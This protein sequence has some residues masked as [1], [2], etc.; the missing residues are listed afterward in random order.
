MRLPEVAR[1]EMDGMPVFHIDGPRPFT[2]HLVFRVGVYDEALRD[3]GI[4]HLVEHLALHPLR[5]S[6][7]AFNGSVSSHMTTFTAQGHPDEVGQFLRSVCSSIHDLGFDRLPVEVDVLTREEALR[8]FSQFD[9]IMWAYF[10][11]RGPGVAGSTEFGLTWLPPSRIAEWAGRFFTRDNA[12]ILIIGDPPDSF[13]L[14]L[15][16]GEPMHY[17][18]PKR[19]RRS[20]ESPTLYTTQELGLTWGTLIRHPKGAA[21]PSFFVGLDTVTQRLQD[22]LRHDLGRT[23]SIPHGWHRIDAELMAAS[24]GFDCDPSQAR[25]AALEHLDVVHEFISTGPTQE[26]LDR[27]LRIQRKG[28]EDHPQAAAQYHLFDEAESHLSGW[29]P[30]TSA[31]EYRRQMELLTA[32]EVARRFEE[33]YRQ[34][35]TVADLPPEK[36]SSLQSLIDFSATPLPGV[37]FQSPLRHQKHQAGR[38]RIGPD[39]FS[40]FY[41]EGWLNTQND[42]IG[43]VIADEVGVHLFGDTSTVT[44]ESKKYRR[45]SLSRPLRL[46]WG[47]ALMVLGAAVAFG[48]DAGLV[49]LALA[50]AGGFLVMTRPEVPGADQGEIKNRKLSM[51]DAVRHYVP[52]ELILPETRD[53]TP[54]DIPART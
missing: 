35:Y 25:E 19:S 22:K 44:F 9:S 13:G 29:G 8:P 36:L 15:P 26:E 11:P 5:T 12:A 50:M 54:A 31:T 34:S 21:E 17:V 30:T 51:Q 24:H 39:G 28:Y 2:A 20:P 53:Q 37:Q 45:S 16:G 27:A 49:G 1:S 4:S 32:D 18:A 48:L 38:V 10:G 46:L 52:E 43:L 40:A 47:L 3:R 7:I 6:E 14:D 33:A 41:L 42:Q 23:Y